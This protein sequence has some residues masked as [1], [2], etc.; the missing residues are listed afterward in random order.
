M[1]SL[2]FFIPV[3]GIAASIIIV[4]YH[5]IFEKT[6]FQR[7]GNCLLPLTQKKNQIIIPLLVFVCVIFALLFIRRFSLFITLI[8]TCSLAIELGLR[9]FILQKRG[10]VYENGLI[11][12]G[13]F[14]TKEEIVSFPTLAYEN[15]TEGSSSVPPEILKTVTKNNG[16]IF[17][18]FADFNERNNAVKIMQNWVE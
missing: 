17:L 16:V 18:E 7:L 13:R 8:A 11:T 5:L 15:D 10:G 9:D 12:S 1:S 3:A 14:L 6:K 4:L 2:Y